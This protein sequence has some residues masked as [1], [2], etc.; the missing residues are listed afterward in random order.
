[1]NHKERT[2]QFKGTHL[3]AFTFCFFNIQFEV[4][5]FSNAHR[6]SQHPL[7]SFYLHPSSKAYLNNLSHILLTQT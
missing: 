2:D 4:T 6:I 5:N 7:I 3:F 1:M